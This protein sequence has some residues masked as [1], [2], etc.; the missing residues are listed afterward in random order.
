MASNNDNLLTGLLLG[1]I[2]GLSLGILFAPKSGKELRD[3][4]MEEGDDMLG[5]AKDELETVKKELE[6]I[7]KKIN[8]TIAR[9]KHTMTAEEQE[10]QDA[11]NSIDEEDEAEE[12]PKKKTRKKTTEKKSD[13]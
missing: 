9:A 5:K 2:V 12:A 13:A 3:D 1:G 11:L 6:S 10:Y 4:L 8:D 7:R